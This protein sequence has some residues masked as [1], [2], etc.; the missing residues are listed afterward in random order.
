MLAAP[1]P[2]V[3]DRRFVINPNRSLSWR[4]NCLF[5]ALVSV[6]LFA[7]AL[8]FA[9]AGLWL[10]APFAGLELL[11]VVAVFY[12]LHRRA[13]LTEIIEISRPSVT[14]SVARERLE[15]RTRLP[16]NQSRVILSPS[17]RRGHPSR[18]FISSRDLGVEVGR[19]LA[20]EE[21]QGLAAALRAAVHAPPVTTKI[22]EDSA[23]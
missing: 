15:R 20:E 8:G 9:L 3:V 6:V 2:D 16:R 5:I 12:V 19:C 11:A 21:R 10:V 13:R 14:I 23:H 4:G 17:A 1:G 22:H 18:L 7:V